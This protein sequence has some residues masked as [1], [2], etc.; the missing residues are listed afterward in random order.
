MTPLDMNARLRQRRQKTRPAFARRLEALRVDCG[1]ETQ[2]AFADLLGVEHATYGRW[3]RGETQPNIDM[4]MK[5]RAVTNACLNTLIVGVG[6][7]GSP[8]QKTLNRLD[9]S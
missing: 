2:A 9:T 1:Y 6:L 7:D 3:E 4:L 5:I 8:K